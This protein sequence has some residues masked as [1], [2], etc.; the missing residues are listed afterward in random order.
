[1][2]GRVHAHAASLYLLQ[3]DDWR[4]LLRRGGWLL[5]VPFVGWP[6]LLGYRRALI[7]HLY[8]PLPRAMPAWRGRLGEHGLNGLR[9]IG[10]IQAHVAPAW[11]LL[12]GM[13]VERGWTPDAAS[14]VLAAVCVVAPIFTN[15]SFPLAC[16][17]AST[18]LAGEA[19]ISVWE[20]VGLLALFTALIAV[21]P[22]AFLR[23]AWTGRFL[24]ALRIDR[25]LRFIARRPRGYALA[26]WYGLWMNGASIVYLVIAPSRVFW[27]Y[28]G[29]LAIFHHVSTVDDVHA[30]FGRVDRGGWLARAERFEPNERVRSVTR[31]EIENSDVSVLRTPWFSMPL[32]GR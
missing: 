22:A 29:S 7:E 1:M 10:V 24:A 5:F 6:I 19:A 8:E 17:A 21:V 11:L 18:P 27:A 26:W 28:V 2:N 3:D 9:A 15:L 12:A 16:V 30:G 14:A 31:T 4:R 20:A 32:R 13:L 23:V 25:S